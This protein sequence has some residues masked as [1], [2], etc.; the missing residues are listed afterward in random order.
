M[1][2][3]IEDLPNELLVAIFSH[4]PAAQLM[5]HVSLV[6]RRFNDV[7]RSEWYWHT[8]YT[9]RSG[10]QLP[11]E[12]ASLALWQRGCLQCEF[13]EGAR[14]NKLEFSRLRGRP[15]CRLM[16]S[17]EVVHFVCEVVNELYKFVLDRV[18]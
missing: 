10:I 18:I 17:L 11:G 14:H 9:Q 2:V 5:C 6:C 13:L 16:T 1:T 7:V 12:A 8:R 3:R 4:M 15:K